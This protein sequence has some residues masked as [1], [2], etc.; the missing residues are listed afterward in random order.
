[1]LFFVFFA[2]CNERVNAQEQNQNWKQPLNHACASENKW[3]NLQLVSI[4]V[5]L[6]LILDSGI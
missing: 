2:D 6:S 5:L 3:I 4:A 1:M